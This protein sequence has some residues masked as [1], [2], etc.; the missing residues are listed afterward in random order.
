[1]VRCSK[2][3]RLQQ[4]SPFSLQHSK[5]P[6]QFLLNGLNGFAQA[7]LPVS[8]RFLPGRRSAVP[9]LRTFARSGDQSCSSFRSR[10]PK[11]QCDKPFLLNKQGRHFYHIASDAETPPVQRRHR[12]GCRKSSI[13]FLSKFVSRNL[14]VPYLQLARSVHLY[15]AGDPRP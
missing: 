11:T 3:L 4:T 7:A 13:S 5:T 15:S 12:Y 10:R 6:S 14:L 8:R 1:M 2:P 9:F